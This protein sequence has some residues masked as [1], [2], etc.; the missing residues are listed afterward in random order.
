MRLKNSHTSTKT[1]IRAALVATLAVGLMA[2]SVFAAKPTAGGGG[3]PSGGGSA[4]LVAAC[5]CYASTPISF[6]GTGYDANRP[7]AMLSFNGATTS[8]AVS[9]TGTIS[10]S[11][12]YFQTA[13]TYWVRAYQ[14]GNGGKMIL[15]AETLVTVQ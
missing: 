10:H 3:K 9:A 8:T 12:P 7:L 14:A 2:G 1:V 5:P 4:T 6:S 13:G 15:K 11:W